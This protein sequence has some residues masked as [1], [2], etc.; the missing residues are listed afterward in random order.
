M[1]STRNGCRRPPPPGWTGP[2]SPSP[3]AV[4]PTSCAPR[5]WRMWR[6][7]PSRAR[8]CSTPGRC[9]A[10]SR[11]PRRTTHRPRPAAGH[12]LRRRGRGRPRGRAVLEELG[13]VGWPKTSGGRGVHVY[14]RICPRWTFTQV[15]RA[16]IALAAGSAAPPPRPGHR[17]LVEGGARPAGL[18]G[19]Q[20]DGPRPHHRLRILPAGQRSGRPCPPRWTGTS[21]P[22]STRTTSPV[23]GAGAAGA[24]GRPA[25]RIDDT[26]GTS[27]H[28]WSGPTGTSGTGTGS[29]R[30]RR[31]TRRC[32]GSRR[33]SS[34]PRPVARAADLPGRRSRRA[35]G[36]H[37]PWHVVPSVGAAKSIR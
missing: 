4:P 27:P 32:R 19:L 3:A 34:R 21:W 24:T 22:T 23:H 6:G 7:R 33:G 5:T 13:A 37:H 14:I 17:V 9:G 31:I 30:T 28:C 36:G 12:R 35:A 29:C 16:V 20:P 15:R 1:P 25:C 26:R 8:S 10:P 2:R 18:P 11:Q